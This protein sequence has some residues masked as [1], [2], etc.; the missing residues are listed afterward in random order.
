VNA[1]DAW[2]RE[3]QQLIDKLRKIEALF[4]RP[5]TEGERAAA[6]NAAE[7]IR[8]RLD[9]LNRQERPREH[10]FSIADPWARMLFLALARRYGLEPYR[11]R[12]QRRTTVMLR[13]GHAFIDDILWPEFRELE[14][15][16]RGYLNDVTQRVIA[17]AI[18]GDV[19]DAEEEGPLGQITSGSSPS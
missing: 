18:H 14:A 6:G 1:S 13:V 3:E 17:E 16:L 5:G 4:A 2:G 10:R 7:R 19:G 8:R 15:T 9:D 11:R 12:G